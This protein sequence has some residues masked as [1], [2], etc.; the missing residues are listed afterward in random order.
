MSGRNI[1]T[2]EDTR[3]GEKFSMGFLEK[4]YLNIVAV[5]RAPSAESW[6]RVPTTIWR[7]DMYVFGEKQKNAWRVRLF[8]EV[9]HWELNQDF[10]RD[11]NSPFPFPR[12]FH[13]E[14]ETPADGINTES[15]SRAR[16][17]TCNDS[18]T[19]ELGITWETGRS[20]WGGA[21]CLSS[22]QIG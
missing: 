8:W 3:E 9:R 16:R 4:A 5:I 12:R 15:G 20:T 2:R 19:P 18:K 10:R 13:G 21:I 22:G 11:K 17:A 7:G 1:C 6:N 14:G